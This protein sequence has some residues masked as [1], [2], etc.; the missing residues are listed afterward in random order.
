MFEKIKKIDTHVHFRDW[1]E[2]YKETIR[3]GSEKAAAQGIIAVGDMPNTKP[4]ILW[5][6]IVRE[7][8]E[9]AAKERPLVKY[10]L[11]VGLTSK[12]NQIEEAVRV[13]RKIPQVIGLKFYA[14]PT[15]GG[16]GT[17]DEEEQKK[18]Y[19]ILSELNYR[20]VLAVHCEKKK[21]L[22]PELWNPEK[23][24]THGEARPLR[25]EIEAVKDQIQFAKRANF[26]GNLHV[27][28]ASCQETLKMVLRA[29]LDGLRTSCEI[30]P[31]HL[32]LTEKQMREREGL[33]F[34]V[35]PPL[36]KTETVKGL[37]KIFLDLSKRGEKW[38]WIATDY[39]PH[40]L[41]EKLGPN[42]P[43]GI[44]DYSLYGQLLDWLKEKG[45]SPFEIE[46]LTFHNIVKTFGEKFKI[47]PR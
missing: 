20:G 2:D 30:T 10:F 33:R 37:R 29:K 36:R 3:G 27:C 13:E 41:E 5:E 47:R 18:I 17:A 28:H 12:K 7:R 6:E 39:A 8:L 25:A 4:P 44:A 40:T 43:S 22:K 21:E 19:D 46:R 35:N 32:L 1:S 14:G 16:L 24:W 23:P 11:W 31:H 26:R 9:L 15:T 34:K 45:L 42:S 38:L